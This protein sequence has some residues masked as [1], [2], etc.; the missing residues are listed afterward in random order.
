ML[1][2]LKCTKL[3]ALTLLCWC[4][5][6]EQTYKLQARRV[7]RFIEQDLLCVYLLRAW[8]FINCNMTSQVL[9][10]CICISN[11]V[12]RGDTVIRFFRC[13]SIFADRKH[14]KICYANIILQW[15]FLW[16]WLVPATHQHFHN[17]Y[18]A[19]IFAYVVGSNTT[20]H[21]VLFTTH[22]YLFSTRGNWT[23]KIIFVQFGLC[24]NYFMQ[25][26]FWQKFTRW[27][28]VNYGMGIWQCSQTVKLSFAL[29]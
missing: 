4:L 5:Y 15:K 27:K 22:G 29:G 18:C 20:S 17:C 8:S 24:E 7:S 6:F 19:Y 10:H 28:R 25:I 2:N 23:C 14:M 21:R 9:C 1:I 26:F 11:S 12:E 3:C 13:K 16:H